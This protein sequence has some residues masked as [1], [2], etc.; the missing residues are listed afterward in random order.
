MLRDQRVPVDNV[1]AGSPEPPL[2]S[3]AMRAK[4]TS[5]SLAAEAM[6]TRSAVERCATQLLLALD[7]CRA[8]EHL[9]APLAGRGYRTARFTVHQAATDLMEARVIHYAGVLALRHAE[10]GS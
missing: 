4:L 7:R 9:R 6:S 1:D 10:E 2:P 8:L 5:A 3:G